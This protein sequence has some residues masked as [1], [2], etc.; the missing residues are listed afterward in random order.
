M[1]TVPVLEYKLTK[2]GVFYYKWNGVSD[3]FNKLPI[4]LRYKE[5]KVKLFPTTVIQK[6]Q[7]TTFDEINVSNKKVLF[8][9]K[10]N[11]KL[12]KLYNK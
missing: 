8:A 4:E 9:K 5:G 2:A 6:F 12:D 11:R 7:L 3:D 10:K 1:N